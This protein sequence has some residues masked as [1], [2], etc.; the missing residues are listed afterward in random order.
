MIHMRES[1]G[2]ELY[3]FFYFLKGHLQQ[4]TQHDGIEVNK[5][6]SVLNI[7]DKLLL[8]FFSKIRILLKYQLETPKQ[9]LRNQLPIYEFIFVFALDYS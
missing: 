5:V 8:L 7:N 1:L 6:G 3:F 9:D 4:S 2:I